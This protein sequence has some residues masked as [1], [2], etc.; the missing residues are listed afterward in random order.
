MA[1]GNGILAGDE[2]ARQA[3]ASVGKGKSNANVLD[4]SYLFTPE[5]YVA[6]EK[7]LH[8]ALQSMGV[9]GR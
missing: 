7:A 2:F 5:A 8:D 3:P 1:K 4:L 9:F 6:R